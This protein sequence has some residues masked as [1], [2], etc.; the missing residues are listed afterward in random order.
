MTDIDFDELDKAVNS[1][2]SKQRAAEN[3][4]DAGESTTSDASLASVN[5]S[6]PE[7]ASPTV[8][9]A[10]NASTDPV[11]AP[12]NNNV[13]GNIPVSVP[14]SSPAMQTSDNQSAEAPAAK[15]GT[16]APKP[17][18]NT[19][20]EA[21][22]VKVTTV[23]SV[24]VSSPTSSVPVAASV[25]GQPSVPARSL[26][27]SASP[28][29]SA[30][31]NVK[32]PTVSSA[33]AASSTPVAAPST[34]T[35][36]S[37]TT[38]SAAPIAATAPAATTNPPTPAPSSVPLSSSSS[39]NSVV[40]PAAQ[41]LKPA[42]STVSISPA[43]TTPAVPSAPSSPSSSSSSSTASPVDSPGGH[44]LAVTPA[45]S[46]SPAA[47]PES[48][49][50]HV[51]PMIAKRPHGRFMDVVHPSS[52]SK[53]VQQRKMTPNTSKAGL[54]GQ[55]GADS[56]NTDDSANLADKGIRRPST[57]GGGNNL[58]NIHLNENNSGVDAPTSANPEK[59]LLSSVKKRVVLPQNPEGK[60]NDSSDTATPVQS[61]SESTAPVSPFISN[62][63]VEKRPLGTPAAAT[64]DANDG[65]AA[66]AKNDDHKKS[67]ANYTPRKLDVSEDDP[68]DEVEPGGDVGLPPEFSADVMAAEEADVSSLDAAVDDIKAAEQR[69]SK[70]PSDNDDVSPRHSPKKDSTESEPK[71]MFDAA[72]RTSKNFDPK[73][74]SKS[75][76]LTVLLI[77]LFLAIGVAG[78]AAAYFLLIK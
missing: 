31:T 43:S 37:A 53:L 22:A 71:P 52:K 57:I 45:V 36:P 9:S 49:T 28:V 59:S 63:E 61:K 50:V 55:S 38:A 8:S 39:P 46:P 6:S 70:K 14:H 19:E 13:G 69:A 32:P 62:V 3:K 75:G 68:D 30:A 29:P 76:W 20:A 34:S 4:T 51:S 73:E 5:E 25:A 23:S 27:P 15:I 21:N 54:S 41:R 11:S 7:L 18:P 56:V 1:L 58:N 42:A 17:S 67:L 40:T 16:E 48:E 44:K 60:T 74:E 78:G 66:I 12:V 10:E 26:T 35:T 77:L 65:S 47:P 24:P 72:S 2:M 33:P 64:D